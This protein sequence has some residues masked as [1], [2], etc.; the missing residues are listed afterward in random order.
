VPGCPRGDAAS[1][2]PSGLAGTPASVPNLFA[3]LTML[4][5]ALNFDYLDY[6]YW[7]L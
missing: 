1:P 7:T 6:V 4:P 3:N 2:L 5:R